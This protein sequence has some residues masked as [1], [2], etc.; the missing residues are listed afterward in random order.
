MVSRHRNTSSTPAMEL[1]VAS[2]K[3]TNTRMEQSSAF[4]PPHHHHHPRAPSER[5]R[6]K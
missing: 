4:T 6:K 5:M 3:L 1:D 2:L